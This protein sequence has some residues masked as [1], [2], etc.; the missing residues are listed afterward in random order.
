MIGLYHCIRNNLFF[1]ILGS[2][3]KLNSTVN[4]KIHIHK[5]IIDFKKIIYLFNS[6]GQEKFL[7]PPLY[8]RDYRMM[9][10]VDYNFWYLI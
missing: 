9:P 4:F 2:V 10:G 5:L 8:V 6:L 3:F 1:N 7:A